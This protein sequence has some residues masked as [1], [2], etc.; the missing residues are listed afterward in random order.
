MGL[1]Q[2]ASD[3][4]DTQIMPFRAGFP[5]KWNGSPGLLREV[6]RRGD[7]KRRAAVA[8]C[9]WQPRDDLSSKD[10]PVNGGRRPCI[11]CA[12]FLAI[13]YLSLSTSRAT[14]VRLLV[15]PCRLRAAPFSVGEAVFSKRLA[16]EARIG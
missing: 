9:G 6:A 14:L 2:R 3:V 11:V 10:L 4:C 8:A 13:L 5:L 16:S 1:A 15:E 7:L 12:S